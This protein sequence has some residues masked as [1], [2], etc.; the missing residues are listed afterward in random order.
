VTEP[1]RT[2]EGLEEYLAHTRQRDALLAS[3]VGV[4]AAWW[5]TNRYG[6]QPG[7]DGWEVLPGPF[8]LALVL[9]L[10]IGGGVSYRL[11]RNWRHEKY[12]KGGDGSR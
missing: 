2:T 5:F 1:E 11:L 9:S 7:A 6:Y 10:A 8:L 3:M 12:L 4:V